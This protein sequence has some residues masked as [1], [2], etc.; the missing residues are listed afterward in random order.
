MARID[1][2]LLD[3]AMRQR[4]LISFKDVIAAGGGEHHVNA[5]VNG[6]RWH[7][8]DHGVYLL[9]GAPLDWEVRQLAA[10]LGAGG[11]S[12]GSHFAAARVLGIDG[13]AQ[14]GVELAVPRGQRFRR[15]GIR[16]HEST[17][18]HLAQPITR[19]AIP[20]TGPDRTI[21]DVARF[22]TPK[23]LISV[24]EA[25][26]R[27]GLVTW[28]SLIQVL[29]DHARRG[30][31]GIRKLRHLILTQAAR[32]EITDSDFE[33]LVLGLLREAGLPEPELHHRVFDG[34]RFIAEVDIAYPQLRIAIECDGGVH[35]TPEVHERDLARQNDLILAGWTVIR[36]TWRRVQARPEVVANEVAAAIRQAAAR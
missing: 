1:Q 12:L 9:A 18:L 35:R 23:R 22:V 15:A 20:I 34:A 14:A 36:F 24:A 3:V 29:T 19:R 10:L 8:V 2:E 4:M 31:P 6:G 17:D 13:F 21:L 26:R 5:R 28:G 11:Q 7:R 33:L 27:S 25:A 30:R 32:Q 16:V